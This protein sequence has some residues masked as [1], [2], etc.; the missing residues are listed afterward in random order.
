MMSVKEQV[1]EMVEELSPAD[2]AVVAR[3]LRGLRAP[4]GEMDEETRAWLDADLGE[5]LLPYD[6]GDVDPMTVGEPLRYVPGVGW[7]GEE[8][9]D[10]PA[11]RHP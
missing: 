2:L 7:V 9:A 8:S 10:E 1:H 11:S 6:W 3:M 4:A 5:R